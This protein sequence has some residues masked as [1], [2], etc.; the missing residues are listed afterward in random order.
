MEQKN[1]PFAWRSQGG[2]FDIGGEDDCG[3]S[4]MIKIGDENLYVVSRKGI[5]SITMADS[6][7]PQRKNPNVRHA[8]QTI[9]SYGSDHELVG[10][11]L[12]QTN[13]L[14]GD[15]F[16][17][18]RRIES[19]D[20][21]RVAFSFLK[22]VIALRELA[23]AY[24]SEE[25]EKNSTF[26]GRPGED[27]TLSVPTIA[28]VEQKAKLFILNSGHAVRH[29]MGLAQL[30]YPDITNEK[31]VIKLHEKLKN[32][33]GPDDHSVKFVHEIGPWIWLMRNLRNAVEHEIK[34]DK[35]E[36]KNYRPTEAGVNPPTVFYKNYDT[37]LPEIPLSIFMN[38]TIESLVNC[39]E[40]L[41]VYLCQ[42]E[43]E[44]RGDMFLSLA[45][46]PEKDRLPHEMHVRFRYYMFAKSENSLGGVD[47]PAT[48]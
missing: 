15:N 40:M 26:Q 32:K 18:V 29:I 36:I 10:R 38:N 22:E 27:G 46:I 9:L 41:L 43:A 24:I 25:S 23:D 47:N 30:F 19:K 12:L 8:K 4:A 17:V 7:D 6:I 34:N 11:I 13:V 16:H 48:Q 45:E 28:N 1:D 21:L 14:L 2:R 44:P 5:H 33:L 35:V 31:W 20:S 42:S 39:F 37:P 3:I